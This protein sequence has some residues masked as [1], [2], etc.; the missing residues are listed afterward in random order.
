LLMVTIAKE[1]TGIVSADSKSFSR[2]LF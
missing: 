2:V 1:S